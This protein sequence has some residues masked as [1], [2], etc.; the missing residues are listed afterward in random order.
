MDQVFR[1]QKLRWKTVDINQGSLFVA[2]IDLKAAF[3][4]GPRSKLW[5]SLRNM[6][7]PLPLLDI[8]MRRHADNYN[9]L[10]G[11]Q[12]GKLQTR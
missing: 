5:G 6:G 9:T 3:D 10:G 8:I 11:E 12:M 4:M 1:F 7:I 2:F